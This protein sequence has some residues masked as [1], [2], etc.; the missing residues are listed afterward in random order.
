M[1]DRP[2]DKILISRIDC[3]AVIGVTTEERA[4]KQRLSIDIEFSL[5]SRSAARSDSIRDTVDYALVARAAAEVC[6]S[7]AFH[8]IETVAEEIASRALSEFPIRQIRVLIRKIAPV[9]EPGV[10]YVSI[11]INRP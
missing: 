10:D 3:L 9:A 11:E 1:A 4:L 8:L 7:R 5:D 2:L 6:S